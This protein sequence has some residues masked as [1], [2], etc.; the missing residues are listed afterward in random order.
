[1]FCQSFN[2]NMHDCLF[3]L[4]FVYATKL[5]LFELKP[6]TVC[7]CVM[8]LISK[9]PL[10]WF[11]DL[12]FDSITINRM[13]NSNCVRVCAATKLSRISKIT[14]PTLITYTYTWMK[15][16]KNGTVLDRSFASTDWSPSKRVCVINLWWIFGAQYQ[17]NRD[18]ASVSHD[19]PCV[20]AL[21]LTCGIYAY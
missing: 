5:N 13:M 19:T 6:Q 20:H 12:W 21:K 11:L 14:Y 8:G 4:L 17:S 7:I 2:R 18:R 15:K 3:H 10:N 16:K 9:I 1:M